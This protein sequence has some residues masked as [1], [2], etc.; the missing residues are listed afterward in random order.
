MVRLLISLTSRCAFLLIARLYLFT[1]AS[2]GIV[3]NVAVVAVLEGFGM[4][5]VLAD[6]VSAFFLRYFEWV[7]R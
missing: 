2:F 1:N 5:L 3:K 7:S 6:H 4:F